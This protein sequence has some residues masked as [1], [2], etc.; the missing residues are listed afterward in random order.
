MSVGPTIGRC[1]S[2]D[3]RGT[4]V[5]ILWKLQS[6]GGSYDPALDALVLTS[7]GDRKQSLQRLVERTASLSY[8]PPSPRE[9]AGIRVSQ[10]LQRTEETVVLPEPELD[11]FGPLTPEALGYLRGPGRN[12]TEAS[13]RS[14]DL[15]WHGGA[16]R[17]A[18]PVRDCAGRLVGIT[19][20]ALD[21]DAVPTYLHSTG[22]QRDMYLFGEARLP[23]PRAYGV[24]VE[25]F[26]DVIYLRQHGY[27]GVALMGT[28]MSG[29]QIEKLVRFFNRVVL[30]LDG[31]KAGDSATRKAAQQLEGSGIQVSKIVTQDGKDPDD[32]SAGELAELLGP[33]QQDIL[34]KLATA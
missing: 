24:L 3:Y 29:L 16:R 20:R 34:D 15:R 8:L 27:P 6:L 13:I 4:P 32:Y 33:P 2:C 5:E 21:A 10:R 9:V 22:F 17:V 23:Q 1:L 30:F 25:G 26:F 19:G 12:L 31:D 18:I 11:L 7:S 28:S 14:W